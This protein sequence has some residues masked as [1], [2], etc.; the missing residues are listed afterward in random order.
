MVRFMPH[1]QVW[2]EMT[3]LR[4]VDAASGGFVAPFAYPGY[5]WSCE[6]FQYPLPTPSFSTAADVL[7]SLIYSS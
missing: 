4:I 1:P 5:K 6:F 7:F 2:V 3:I